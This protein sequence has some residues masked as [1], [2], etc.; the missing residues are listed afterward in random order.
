MCR[1]VCG[2]CEQEFP[3]PSL[4]DFAYG[5]FILHRQDGR[6]FCYLHAIDNAVWDFVSARV[7]PLKNVPVRSSGVILQEVVAR[8]ADKSDG[9]PFTMRMVC[10]HC[11]SHH[12][13]DWGRE[14]ISVAEVP[15]ATFQS[16]ASLDKRGKESL[17]RELEKQVRAEPS[18]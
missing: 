14:R 1:A 6:S 18:D 16:F 13:R 2:E 8:L 15:D 7:Q 3:Y 5:E 10:P 11:K 12:F 17:I 9:Q 4:N